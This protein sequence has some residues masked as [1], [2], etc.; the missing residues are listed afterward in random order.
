MATI[1][2]AGEILT[3]TA[4]ADDQRNEDLNSDSY[5]SKKQYV[6]Y[7]KGDKK[8]HVVIPRVLL[9]AEKD[10]RKRT[11]VDI[12]G[13]PF[14][15]DGS[16]YDCS[17]DSE[18]DD[19]SFQTSPPISTPS[20]PRVRSD[21]GYEVAIFASFDS[22]NSVGSA[23]SEANPANV[24]DTIIRQSFGSNKSEGFI[25]ETISINLCD[26]ALG[27]SDHS[28]SRKGQLSALSEATP[29]NFNDP[30]ISHSSGSNKSGGSAHS[31]KSPL[32]LYEPAYNLRDPPLGGSNH[33][34]SKSRKGRLS[35]LSEASP[36]NFNDPTISH[37]FGSDKNKGSAHSERSLS[38]LQKPAKDE[39]FNSKSK[40]KKGR[41]SIMSDAT[42]IHFHEPG[43]RDESISLRSR[44]S[45]G[46]ELSET[47]PIRFF[48]STQVFDFD[49][50]SSASSG[51]NAT[52][53]K[54]DESR[55]NLGMT[56]AEKKESQRFQS[57]LFDSAIDEDAERDIVNV[58][59][60]AS[61][62]ADRE[63]VNL[64]EDIYSFVLA[65]SYFSLEFW[66]AIY[67]ILVKYLCYG[68]VFMN[69]TKETYTGEGQY[70]RVLATKLIMIPVAVAMQEDLITVYYNVAN[71]RYDALTYK[72]NIYATES[73]WIL[74]NVLRAIDGLMSLAVNFGV[75]LL[76]IDLLSI[77]LSFAALHFLQFI[78]D[79]I[80]ELAEKGF[81][82]HKLEQA[83]IA[84]KII[85]FTR[86]T[87][88]GNQ[89]NNFVTNLDTILLLGSMAICL[90]IYGYFLTNFYS[91]E[92]NILFGDEK[93]P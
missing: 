36:L 30:T 50:E 61:A 14:E 91:D 6:Y 9:N 52:P 80:Y 23:L 56:F 3:V 83:T 49:L 16:E 72:G 1:N 32:N 51:S 21:E 93:E 35:A 40:S 86:R 53:T 12:D 54:L 10:S 17:D 81:F 4:I 88:S 27:E 82:G 90:A 44:K 77:F 18:S 47:T 28:K 26:H 42:P 74:S 71:K 65:C 89:C 45:A 64:T 59:L 29:L 58:Y 5:G 22:K 67:F 33:S 55:R 13:I 84:C 70:P 68:V 39:S 73:K 11:K 8:A 38:S 48:E 19:K 60:E 24:R 43:E 79:V 76:E 2:I 78:D 75:M 63:R 41:M 87:Q 37:S 7:S 15:S 85:T 92:K 31:E 20:S 69:L 66:T 57:E 46:T 25:S 62:F 34:K